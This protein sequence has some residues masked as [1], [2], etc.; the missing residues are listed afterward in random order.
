M[1]RADFDQWRDG[2]VGQWFFDQILKEEIASRDTALGS[3]SAL[4]TNPHEIA[5]LYTQ[6]VGMTAGIQLVRSLDPFKEERNEDK[7]SRSPTPD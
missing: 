3:G 7:T 4:S 5:F 2:P 1:Q 6:E